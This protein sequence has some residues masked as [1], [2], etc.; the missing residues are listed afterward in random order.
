MSQ[1]GTLVR[2]TLVEFRTL[3]AAET[4]ERY[5]ARA[6][7]AQRTDGMWE[8]WIEFEPLDGGDV[9]SSARETTQPNLTDLEYWA[10]GLTP[11]YLEGALKRALLESTNAASGPLGT[12]PTLAAAV[13]NPFTLHRRRPDL[14]AQELCALSRAHLIAIIEAYELSDSPSNRLDDL[15]SADLANLI[16][17][18]VAA[19]RTA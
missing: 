17:R 12:E 10:T 6:V 3:I 16:V 18:R 8:G 15:S 19:A 13:L 14:L 5:Q 2:T 7:G 4:G 1:R 9:L 11:V